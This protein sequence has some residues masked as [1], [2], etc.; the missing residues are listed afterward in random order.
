MII[1]DRLRATREEKKLAQSDIEKRTD[2]LRCYS[3]SYSNKGKQTFRAAGCSLSLLTWFAHPER[4][5]SD[6]YY[7][8][9]AFDDQGL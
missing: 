4:L 7:F 8:T 5:T 9:I 3:S 2:P 6:N 1:G